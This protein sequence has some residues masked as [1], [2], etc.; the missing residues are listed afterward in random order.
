[1]CTDVAT[2]SIVILQAGVGFVSSSLE[3]FIE[4]VKAVTAR[5]PF[6]SVKDLSV[7]DGVVDGAVKDVMDA[8]RSVDE[9]ALEEDGF[10]TSLVDDIQMGDFATEWTVSPH[11][12]RGWILEHDDD[13]IVRLWRKRQ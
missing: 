7:D 8:I 5:F 6:Y 9:R 4:T 13:G 2:G 3:K 11:D 12:P 10:W 1:M